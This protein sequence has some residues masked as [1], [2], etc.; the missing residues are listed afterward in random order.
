M[1]IAKVKVYFCL[2]EIVSMKIMTC[3]FIVNDSNK[4]WCNM[5]ISRDLLKLL[6][7]GLNVLDDTTVCIKGP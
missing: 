1:T 2:P 3:K 7:M 4:G 5:I 6:E